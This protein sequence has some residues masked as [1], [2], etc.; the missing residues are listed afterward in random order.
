MDINQEILNAYEVIKEGGIILYPT[1]TV[2]GIGCDASNPD[3][4]AKIYKLKQR[5][6]TQS[7][8][9][10]MNGEKMIYNVFNEIPQ[11]PWQI[12]AFLENLT[13]LVFDKLSNININLITPDST[14]EI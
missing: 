12:M 5:A 9:C 3:A 11:V 2:W 13:T 8:I 4:V 7:M 6:E 14:L 1:D 10:L